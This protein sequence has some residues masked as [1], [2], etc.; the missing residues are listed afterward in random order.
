MSVI[1]SVDTGYDVHSI[2]I[3]TDVFM[4]IQSGLTIEM[5]GKGF[6]IEGDLTQ[7]FW[8]FSNRSIHVFCENGFEIFNGSLDD[9]EVQIDNHQ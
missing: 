2:V 4:N 5:A 3:E 9:S 7:D 6:S 8:N 1:L